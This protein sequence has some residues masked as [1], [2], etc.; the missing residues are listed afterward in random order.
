MI[1]PIHIRTKNK[2]AAIGGAECELERKL[3][4]KAKD[5]V[6]QLTKDKTLKVSNEYEEDNFGRFIIKLTAEAINVGTEGFLKAIYN[7]DP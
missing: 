1:V 5:W 4:F 3:A 7:F 2:G 6:V